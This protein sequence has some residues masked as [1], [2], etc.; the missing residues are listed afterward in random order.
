MEVLNQKTPFAHCTDI[1]AAPVAV[2]VVVVV[3]DYY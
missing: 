3:V 1:I 2:V